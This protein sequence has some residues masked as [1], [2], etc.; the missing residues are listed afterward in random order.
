M[1]IQPLLTP[2]LSSPQNFNTLS[3]QRVKQ[4]ALV[5]FSSLSIGLG[6]L[7]L[8][9]GT[10]TANFVAF[11]SFSAAGCLIW[12]ISKIKQYDSPSELARYQKEARSMSFDEIIKEHGWE[13]SFQYE[14]P[15]KEFFQEKFLKSME[16]RSINELVSIYEKAGELI[17]KTKSPFTLPNCDAFRTKFVEETESLTTCEILKSYDIEKLHELGIASQDLLESSKKYAMIEENYKDDVKEAKATFTGECREA[18]SK[19]STI[20]HET[21]ASKSSETNWIAKLK[22]EAEHLQTVEPSTWHHSSTDILRKTAPSEEIT[23][24]S[25]GSLH[26]TH[27][28]FVTSFESAKT[29]L[30][31]SI[32]NLEKAREEAHQK[33]NAE[34]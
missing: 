21:T 14:I 34:Y 31:D 4:I 15:K 10:A 28:L 26:Q 30:D 20:L 32:Q 1:K 5:F 3:E 17:K 25:M 33:L 13:N 16:S 9:V 8:S 2:P 12:V 24:E 11:V 7:A 18:L 22:R 6:A 19:F 27:A 23:K 29:A